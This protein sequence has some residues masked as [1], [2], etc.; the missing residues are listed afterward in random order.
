MKKT[1]YNQ[2]KYYNKISLEYQNHYGNEYALKYRFRLYDQLLKKIDLNGKSVLDAMC[3]GGQSS[4]YFDQFD[5]K[6]EGV[7]ISEEQCKFYSLSLP[8]HKIFCSSI[9]DFIPKKKYDIIVTDSLHHLHPNVNDVLYLFDSML[10]KGGYIILWEPNSK[11]IF[12]L[13]RR[14]FYKLD[15]KYFM[16][17]EASINL[18]KVNNKLKNYNLIN[19]IYGGNF[20]YLFLNLSMALRL[21]N[22]Y[23]KYFFK[24]L[25]V[26]ENFINLF[27]ISYNSLWFLAIFKKNE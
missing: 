22:F 16:E 6:I 8:K 5:C 24:Y 2:K 4:L 10:N 19:S 20:G 15:S 3:G 17:N 26:L 1:E 25:M 21:S 9:L 12:D 7:D 13:L 11:S 27:Q 14:L 18:D 23:K